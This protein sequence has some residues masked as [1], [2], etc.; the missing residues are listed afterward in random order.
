[1]P[2]KQ[3]KTASRKVTEKAA[4]SA[5]ESASQAITIQD[6]TGSQVS[7]ITTGLQ[8]LEEKRDVLVDQVSDQIVTLLDPSLILQDSLALAAEKM[9]WGGSQ[10]TDPLDSLGDALTFT[11]KAGSRPTLNPG[12]PLN[13]LSAGDYE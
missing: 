5:T 12:E 2:I 7:Q 3:S 1:M 11:Y 9:A 13:L 10:K 8:A 6:K 4:G